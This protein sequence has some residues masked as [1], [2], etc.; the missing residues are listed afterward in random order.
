[1]QASKIFNN[2]NMLPIKSKMNYKNLNN[3]YMILELFRNHCSHC[4]YR[5]EYYLKVS[6]GNLTMPL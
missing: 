1:M 4:T 6:D 2:H 5:L 3:Y